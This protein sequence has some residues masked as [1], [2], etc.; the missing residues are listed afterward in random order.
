MGLGQDIPRSFSEDNLL[1][2]K[3]AKTDGPSQI[4][5]GLGAPVADADG[6]SSISVL[7][8]LNMLNLT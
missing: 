8:R 3:F 2:F 6:Q 5:M 4:S 7:N 1:T